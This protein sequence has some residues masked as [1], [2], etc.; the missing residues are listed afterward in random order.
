MKEFKIDQAPD[1]PFQTECLS[2]ELPA[3]FVGMCRKDGV[4]PETVLRGFI[5]DVAGITSWVS[6]PRSDG[7]VS[8]GSD[9]RGLA[10][11]YYERVGYP[12]EFWE[13]DQYPWGRTSKS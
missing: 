2:L 1:S 10:M 9:E 12:K 4:E 11:E 7:Y 3:E 5:A 8:N 13:D 6:N